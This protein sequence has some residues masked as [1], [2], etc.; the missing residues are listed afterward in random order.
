M[1]F[2][3]ALHRSPFSPVNNISRTR[4]PPDETRR[5]GFTSAYG[6]FRARGTEVV[7]G[8]ELKSLYLPNMTPAA[9]KLLKENGNF[10]EGQLKHYGF[11]LKCLGASS[12]NA[13][14]I[15]KKLLAE[16]K[17]RRPTT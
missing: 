1:A 12:S 13:T 2:A 4:L 6:R 11:D 15:L 8:E 5:D 7:D 10:S 3:G 9:K 17:V 14:I 16:G